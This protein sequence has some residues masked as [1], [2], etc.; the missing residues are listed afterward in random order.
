MNT[1]I[2]AVPP[3]LNKRVNI[4]DDFSVRKA[5][6]FLILGTIIYFL[7]FYLKGKFFA[8]KFLLFW[9]VGGSIA[10]SAIDFY[11]S[12][13][14]YAFAIPLEQA[15]TN[16]AGGR[17]NT[18][19]YLIVF[20]AIFSIFRFKYEKAFDQFTIF[21]A[22]L[23]VFIVWTSTTLL[24]SKDV[25]IGMG[26]TLYNIGG[27]FIV[28][29]YKG[30]L[31]KEDILIK[32]LNFF[33]YGI[34]VMC[35]SLFYIYKPGSALIKRAG[36]G[37]VIQNALGLGTDLDPQQYARAANVAIILI[38][39]LIEKQKNKFLKNLYYFILIVLAVS[40]PL[41]LNRSS[42]LV[43]LLSLIFFALLS[44]SVGLKAKKIIIVS[45]II[46]LLMYGAFKINP[47][48]LS[49]RLKTTES[50]YGSGDLRRLTSG[51]YY[52][53]KISLNF[54][55]EEFISGLGLGSFPIRFS[56]RTGLPPRANHNAYLK[57]F[58]E[59]GILGF[60]LFIFLIGL[61]GYFAFQTKK[62]RHICLTL[63]LIFA[64]SVFL[65][66]MLRAKDLWFAAAIIISMKF[67]YGKNR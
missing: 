35:V 48:A 32:T 42:I 52:I 58:S 43:Q 47:E 16:W 5:K 26:N 39:Y 1:G 55:K 15:I 41:T 17:F 49:Y 20:L 54:I 25:K 65:H 60:T 59:T 44:P 28:Y 45:G 61:I 63:W 51:R 12:L 18:L 4:V 36:D 2:S 10:F 24:W 50:Y 23:I 3:Y 66:E 13:Y 29:F 19:T 67:L 46:F 22:I 37:Q 21:E 31:K 8:C 7:L 27:F 11:T 62:Y 34:L 6:Y 9:L 64:S 14:I 38:F 33:I 53:W 56:L 30:F 57:Y 40:I